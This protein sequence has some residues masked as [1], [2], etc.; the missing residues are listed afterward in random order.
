MKGRE[1]AMRSG[2][3]IRIFFVVDVFSILFAMQ[4]GFSAQAAIIGCKQDF[5]NDAFEVLDTFDMSYIRT[6]VKKITR[7]TVDFCSGKIS[8]RGIP[9]HRSFRKIYF[10][11]AVKASEDCVVEI[12]SIELDL[13]MTPTYYIA[14]LLGSLNLVSIATDIGEK[15]MENEFK[16]DF[17]NMV[18]KKLFRAENC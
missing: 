4:L 10:D 12:K 18:G 13:E 9:K 14:Q 5:T 7:F 11:A 2:S 3:N 15:L 16:R 8:L 1:K 6:K 17:K